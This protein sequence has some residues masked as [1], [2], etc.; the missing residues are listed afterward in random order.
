MKF[1]QGIY[2]P[3]DVGERWR[4]SLRHV[5]ALEWTLQRCRGRRTA[6]QAGG[7]IG[8][9]P[10]RMKAAGF[11]RVMTFEPDDVSR[12]CLERNVPTAD[13]YSCALGVK[14]GVCAIDHRS[15]GSHRVIEGQ[16]HQVV[17]LDSF[18]LM[19]LDL[20]QLDIEGYEW[21]AL[22]GA[23]DTIM[24]CRPLI[25]IELRGFT[26]KYGHSDAEVQA[27]IK[28]FDYRLVKTLPGN[29]FVFEPV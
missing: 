11:H 8:L 15:L 3:D 25:H 2:W 12:A 10:R 17:A 6:V 23:E 18:G 28:S 24:R 29:D 22:V 9:W 27:L 14:Q 26:E 19:A 16:S 21:H 5:E 4:H 7:N 20:L 13:I 1:I